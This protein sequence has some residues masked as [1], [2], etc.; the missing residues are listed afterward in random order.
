LAPGD[1]NANIR[2]QLLLARAAAAGVRD[3]EG[4]LSALGGSARAATGL[5]RE[6]GLQVGREV[7]VGRWER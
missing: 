2:T 4:R 5:A 3:V 6:E 1:E 7:R